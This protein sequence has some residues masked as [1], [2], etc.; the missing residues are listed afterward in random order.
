MKYFKRR[1]RE[2]R[3][4]SG[5]EHSRAH[6]KGGYRLLRGTRALS[7]VFTLLATF[8]ATNIAIFAANTYYNLDTGEIVVNEVQRV[9][10]A[11]RAT[12]G[13][14]VGG[15]AVQDPT[16]GYE[17]EVVDTS[18][19]GVVALFGGRVVGSN[20]VANNEFV[21]LGQL[22]GGGGDGGA[23][24]AFTLGGN[25]FGQ[26][27]ILGTTDAED[28][29]IIAGGGSSKFT[30]LNSDPNVV[31]EFHG[32]VRGVNA[33]AND[34]LV[35]LGQLNSVVGGAALVFQSNGY[36]FASYNS[37]TTTLSLNEIDIVSDTNLGAGTGLAFTGTSLGVTGV[38]EDL[39]TLGAPASDGQ[40]I[41][42]T[43]VGTFAYESGATARASL[44]LT[45]GTDVQAYSP[46]LGQIAGLSDPNADR[47]M[48]WDDSANSYAYLEVSTG[49]SLSGTTLSV[50]SATEAVAG[51]A[52]FATQAEVNANT[53]MTS[54]V[55]PGTLGNW[56]GSTSLTTVGTITNGTWQGTP[57]A[58]AYIASASNWNAAY[59]WGNH[60]LAG[61]LDGTTI[62]G[63]ISDVTLTTLAPG[64]ILV[65]DGTGWV[66][67]DVTGVAGVHDE[68]TLAGGS[69]NYISLDV[70]SQT[71]T[72]AAVNLGTTNVTGTLPVARG[73][74]GITSYTTGYFL[75]A[76]GPGTLAERSPAQVL[77]D[78]GA[79]PTS[80]TITA[81]TGLTGGGDLSTNRTIAL[82]T[83]SINSLALADTALQ[84]ITGLISQGANITITGAGTSA[85]PYVIASN[86]GTGG[87]G[88]PLT[89]YFKEGGN[90]FGHAAVLGTTDANSLSFVTGVGGTSR[91]TIGAAGGVTIASG[92]DF[93]VSGGT[94]S[95]A[96]DINLT[97]GNRTIGTTGGSLN[98]TASGTNPIRL[99]SASTGNIEFFNNQNFIDSSGNLTIAGNFSLSG[100]TITNNG[101]LTTIASTG[102]DGLALDSA[103]GVISL[104]DNQ[105]LT[106]NGFD[107]TSGSIFREVHPIFGFDVPIRC[108]TACDGTF[109]AIS[110]AI[111]NYQFPPAYAGTTRQ[112][113]F[114]IHYADTL[115]SGSS[116]W[117]V[118][119]TTTSSV[120]DTFTVPNS[121]TNNLD[122]SAAIFTTGDIDIPTNGD[123]WVLQVSMPSGQT[124]QVNQ[125]F[126]GAYDVIQ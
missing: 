13:L 49:L 55:R 106:D 71:L 125:V 78:I 26:T 52:R 112:H 10:N 98:V 66:N 97:G 16:T 50:N 36:G 116:S 85:S 60:A 63:D 54:V 62:L 25:A 89:E 47:I 7:V 73:G 122:S 46:G 104:G 74:T 53:D 43:G 37:G 23:L 126:L 33:V 82:S 103:T 42:A 120:V 91:M 65:W 4:S 5:S 79:V 38:L 77:A 90:A 94:S 22:L 30:V 80:R 72:V 21:T 1:S 75:R 105:L 99:A 32:R 64:E 100:L 87:G 118:Y 51:I 92:N 14:I 59:G 8:I 81:G 76:S 115:S 34:E 19:N 121:P 88:D 117:R 114:T 83:A 57:I 102:G 58:D 67:D 119:N 110:R 18:G 86:I 44:G 108:S 41:V 20:A 113:N 101:T 95:F 107:L 31:A 93:T 48:F 12:G 35:T 111:E 61:Y 40:I 24:N 11:I 56:N 84:N 69:E 45:I 70:P 28:V 27:A 2:E 3:D 68:L 109:I 123:D 124:L 9:T 6:K 96:G 17:L 39:N 15:T 29:Q